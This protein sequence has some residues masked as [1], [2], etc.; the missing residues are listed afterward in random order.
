MTMHIAKGKLISLEGLDG[1]GK[2]TQ[3]Q[4]M[5]DYLT[6]KGFDVTTIRE[7]G[8]T[9]VGEKIRDVLLHSE[10]DPMTE[11]MLFT[12][13][14]MEIITQRIIPSLQQG[15]VV[16]AD[17]F[18]DSTYAY[19]GS[20]RGL[21]NSVIYLER[22]I[23]EYVEVDYT[24]YFDVSVELS[25]ERLK[26]AG[27]ALDRIDSQT[28]EFKKRVKQ[29]FEDRLLNEPKRI[30]MI[31]ADSPEINVSQQIKHWLD[32]SFIPYNANIKKKP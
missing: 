1:S 4:Y 8:G 13:S 6:Q 2:T 31:Q 7:P 9:A 5:Q 27:K 14:R 10:M 25:I 17:R 3:I 12:S 22:L 32:R 29:G 15:K 20:G 19:Q 24:L 11:L 26:K 30:T 16:L 28:P 23:R 18:I 21:T